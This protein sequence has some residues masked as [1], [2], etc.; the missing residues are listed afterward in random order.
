MVLGR[1]E[2]ELA[3]QMGGYEG[4]LA[5]QINAFTLS[6]KG[7]CHL[8]YKSC[9]LVGTK[10]IDTVSD[11]EQKSPDFDLGKAAEGEQP[12]AP[13]LGRT[14]KMRKHSHSNFALHMPVKSPSNQPRK[15]GRKNY[16]TPAA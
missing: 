6:L 8:R 3:E 2:V 16:I 15:E 1:F 9:K 14:T 10:S 11:D 13:L 7:G 5:R 12:G 4:L